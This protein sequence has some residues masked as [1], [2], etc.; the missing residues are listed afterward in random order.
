MLLIII[1]VFSLTLLLVYRH[2]YNRLRYVLEVFNFFGQPCNFSELIT[3]GNILNHHDWGPD[4]VWTQEDSVFVFSSHLTSQQQ[5]Q[6]LVVKSPKSGHAK[7]CYLWFDDNEW[8]PKVGKL[9]YQNLFTNN[10]Y[11]GYY[12]ICEWTEAA[13]PYAV[14]YSKK[15]LVKNII[16]QNNDISNKFKMT[17]CVPPTKFLTKRFLSEFLS[18]HNL[19]GVDSF[20]VYSNALPHKT[21][22]L[23]NNLSRQLNFNI[24]FYS[25]NFPQYFE[26]IVVEDCRLRTLKQSNYSVLMEVN[27]YMTPRSGKDIFIA[28]K[29]KTGMFKLPILK[30]CI[31]EQIST[32]PISLQNIYLVRDVEKLVKVVNVHNNDNNVPGNE[33][34]LISSNNNIQRYV[35]CLDALAKVYADDTI[36]KFSDDF[37]KSTLFQINLHNFL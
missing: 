1:S 26:E 6:S 35:F 12:Y 16:V 33:S 34:G 8:K 17:M 23:I 19:V 29:S 14:S 24:S 22:K 18:Y 25:Y 36:L 27:E 32:K 15:Q 10:S 3:S 37:I 5:L 21:V 28:L 30:F 13:T 7:N 31:N 11:E 20:I 9:R 4:P 2:E